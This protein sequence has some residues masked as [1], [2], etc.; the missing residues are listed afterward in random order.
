MSN[1]RAAHPG[2]PLGPLPDI[3]DDIAEH[4]Q[5]RTRRAASLLV[6]AVQA[7]HGNSGGLVTNISEKVDVGR[8][9]RL[10]P[11]GGQSTDLM[12]KLLHGLR[13]HE[14]EMIKALVV[15]PERGV[16]SLTAF[17]RSRSSYDSQK[18]ARSYAVGRL[19]A[20]LETL[21]EVLEPQEV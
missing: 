14:R 10:R 13:R 15:S 1:R 18:T 12:E 21:S 11:P 6:A 9:A 20:M 19:V 7:H 3:F 16:A 8:V 5:P 4:L 17:G 2:A